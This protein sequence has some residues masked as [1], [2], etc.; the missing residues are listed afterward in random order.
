MLITV[1]NIGKGAQ[2]VYANGSAK[3]QFI[4]SKGSK[5]LTVNED[6]LARIER[7][8]T[9]VVVKHNG[10]VQANANKGGPELPLDS[11]DGADLDNVGENDS[12]QVE[13]PVLE[14]EGDDAGD[15]PVDDAGAKP[16]E[17]PKSGT[18]RK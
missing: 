14:G 18:K 3:P 4:P 16:W 17:K 5:R 13:H 6:E 15:P 10:E 11:N 9:L 12:G 8:R 7:I 1:K 2:G